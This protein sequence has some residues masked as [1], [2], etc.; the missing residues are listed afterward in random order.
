MKFLKR[1]FLYTIHTNHSLSAYLFI[2][3]KKKNK[4]NSL[5]FTSFSTSFFQT[6]NVISYK[7]SP[8]YQIIY[9]DAHIKI[10]KLKERRKL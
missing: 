7:Y 9:I 1:T 6:K 3:F 10:I 8:L 4:K 5:N 2:K